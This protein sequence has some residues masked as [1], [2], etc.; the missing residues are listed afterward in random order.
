MPY[1]QLSELGRYARYLEKNV[2]PICAV[3][4]G[5]HN[6]ADVACYL[7]NVGCM[8][9]AVQLGAQGGSTTRLLAS[10]VVAP[11]DSPGPGCPHPNRADGTFVVAFG[12]WLTVDEASGE[13][14][15]M[16]SNVVVDEYRLV[17]P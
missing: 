1:D 5:W 16:P 14:M 17:E 3:Q 4:V 12:D 2:D 8:P 15:V 6:V 7:G 13:L 11:P 10:L 9:L